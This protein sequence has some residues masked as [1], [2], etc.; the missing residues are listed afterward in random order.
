V[1]AT[2]SI[3]DLAEPDLTPR[4]RELQGLAAEYPVTLTVDAVLSA[5]RSRTGLVD[6][7]PDDFLDRL[8]VLIRSVDEDETLLASGRAGVH[9]D[10]VRYGANRLLI[11]D[12]LERHPE[13]R[14]VQIVA[15]VVVAGLPRSGTTHLLN[16]LAADTRF[17]SLPYWES[18]EPVAAT[19][20]QALVAG[21]DPRYTRRRQ[22]WEAT[23]ELLPWLKAMHAM[24]PD[25]IHEELELMGPDFASYN[26]EWRW[27]APRWRDHYLAHDQ[28]PHYAYMK[29][30]LQLLQWQD[31]RAGRPE[32]ERW[33]LKCPQHLEQLPVL[34]ATF[35]DA[36]VV[37]TH[38]DPVSVIASAATMTAY[39]DRMRR[40]PVDPPRTGRYWVDRIE[41]LLRSCV[42]DR[43]GLSGD[44]VLDVR[45]DEFMADDLATVASVYEVAGVEMTGV[46]RR[47]LTGYLAANPRGK[48]GR[49]AYDL[50]GDFG[51]DPDATRARFAFYHDRFGVNRED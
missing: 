27:Y 20:E 9:A 24:T 46:S 14:D 2:I 19:G 50:A 35:P 25:H 44:R 32:R 21:E 37:I 43:D 26:F 11:H 29:T 48:H 51:L 10:L 22:E 5:A 13:I 34:D 30:V 33:V 41:T 36:T 1:S 42:R 3:G 39:G 15:P 45:F 4:Q 18:C 40:S 7:G 8:A 12:R 6:F 47:A 28:T 16:L 23:D 38:R 31:A 17:R 49:L